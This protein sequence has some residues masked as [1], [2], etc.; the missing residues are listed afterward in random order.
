MMDTG[1]LVV[2]AEWMASEAF[3][4]G[5]HGEAAEYGML[6]ILKMFCLPGMPLPIT[7]QPLKPWNGMRKRTP[8]DSIGGIGLFCGPFL[9]QAPSP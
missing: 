5:E 8:S 3:L 7:E 4:F 2:H 9:C 6:L 1:T